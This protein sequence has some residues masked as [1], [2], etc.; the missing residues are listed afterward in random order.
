MFTGIIES[1]GTIT[2][3]YKNGTNKSF[4]VASLLSHQLKV[5]QSLAHDGVCLTVE[6]IKDNQHRVTAVLE[7]LEKTNLGDWETGK[8]INLE[9]CLSFNGRLDGHLVQ[10]HVDTTGTILS[11][12]EQGGSW[13]FIVAYPEQFAALIIEKGSITVNGISLTAFNISNT[14]FEVAIIPYTYEYTN[15]KHLKTGDK[16]NLEFD[17]IG[18]YV[19]RVQQVLV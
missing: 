11:R 4:W 10:G 18:K 13:Q 15:V 14:S 16:A 12:K 1:T 5:D 7:T 2:E 19:S 8:I 17:V 6:E 9:R 3:I